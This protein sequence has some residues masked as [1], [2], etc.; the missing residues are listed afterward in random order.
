MR[1]LFQRQ[2]NLLVLATLFQAMRLLLL[3]TSSRRSSL[4]A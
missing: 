1:R 3:V 2:L 4:E